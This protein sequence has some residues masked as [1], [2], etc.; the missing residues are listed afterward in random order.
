MSAR[1]PRAIKVLANTARRDRDS[2]TSALP[3][4]QA[5]PPPPAWLTSAVAV[6]EWKRLAP[7]MIAN[8]LLNA[9][10]IS[11]FGQYCALHAQ[12]IEEWRSGGAPVA[13]RIA[14]LRSLA[15][16]LGLLGFGMLPTPK[17][18]NRFATNAA[19]ARRATLQ[20]S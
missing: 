7:L 12:L 14:A 8:Q 5:A 4:I 10:N 19:V 6:H 20:R 13:A 17:P 11:I 16:S 3:P 1:R 18:G 9:G 2:G 15:V